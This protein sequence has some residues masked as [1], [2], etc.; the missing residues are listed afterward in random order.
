MPTASQNLLGK[1]V[2]EMIDN[3][4]SI[5]SD[6]SVSGTIK[7][8]DSFVDFN[9]ND[10]S[11]Q[12]GNFFPFVLNVSGNKMTFKK[13]GIATKSNINFDKDIIFR[14]PDK[15]TTFSVEVDGNP[16]ITLNFTNAT[17]QSKT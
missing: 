3:D 16:I 7:Y 2:S 4:I 14:V 6:G 15:N 10:P 1:S 11:E 13:N 5:S 8:I 9:K 12:K 17:L